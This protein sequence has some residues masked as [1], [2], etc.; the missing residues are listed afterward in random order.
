MCAASESSQRVGEDPGHHLGRH[1][2]EDQDEG[3]R[4]LA[5]VGVGRG[6]VGVARM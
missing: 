6:A 5:A 3:D 1:E 2:A 4:Q